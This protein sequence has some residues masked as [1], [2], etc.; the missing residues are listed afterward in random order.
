[1]LD[2]QNQ[3]LVGGQ[4]RKVVA[5]P[6]IGCDSFKQKQ[7]AVRIV[8]EHKLQRELGRHWGLLQS[9]KLR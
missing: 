3:R 7:V 4:T 1:L 6:A 9:K 8:E 2:L 5:N